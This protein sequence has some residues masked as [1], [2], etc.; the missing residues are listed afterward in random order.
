[1]SELTVTIE[2]LAYGIFGVARTEAGVVLVPGTAPGDVAR[3]RVVASKRDHREAELLD[4]L[5]PSPERRTPPCPYV[6]ECGGCSWQ[7]VSHRA[8]LAAKERIVRDALVRIGGL[9][10][11]TLDIRPIIPCDEWAYRHRLSLRVGGEQ[12][13]GFYQHRSHRLVEVAACRIADAA[14]NLHLAAARDWLRGAST[15]VRRLEIASARDARVAFVGNAEGSFRHDEAYHEKFLREH[16]TVSG[17]VLFGKGWRRVFGKPLVDLELEDGLVLETRGGFTQVNPAGNRRLVETVMKL[18]APA[19][20]DRVLDLYCGAGNFTLPCARRGATVLG[21][22]SDPASASQAR[23]NADRAGLANCRFIQQDASA[24][25]HSLAAAGEHYSLVVLDPPRSGAPD[26]V[27]HL[28]VL[29]AG[30]MIYVSCNPATLARDLRRLTAHGFEIGPV[31]PIDLFAQTHHVETV[32]RL[33]RK[34]PNER[35]SSGG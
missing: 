5:R 4:V 22:E 14:V 17:I 11:T 18:A 24:A 26:V 32:V 16:P 2:S 28:P 31:Q 13:L 21:V 35:V 29:V 6:P 3:V 23:H 7:H 15:E 20:S 19:S 8:Q 9:D 25:A 27:D 34:P 33:D 30:R 1:M 10:P 12:R